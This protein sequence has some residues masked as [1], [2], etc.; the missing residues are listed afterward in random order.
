M[1][2]TDKL[3]I[4]NTAIFHTFFF[5]NCQIWFNTLTNKQSCDLY[6]YVQIQMLLMWMNASCHYNQNRIKS[7]SLVKCAY[8]FLYHLRRGCG[9]CVSAA[10]WCLDPFLGKHGGSTECSLSVSPTREWWVM[11]CLWMNRLWIIGWCHWLHN[12]VL[13]CFRLSETSSWWVWL[14][15]WS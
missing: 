3:L 1:M 6:G 13:L 14:R 8:L 4:I 15:F 7:G 12:S 10:L 11:I 9:H 2:C 5:F